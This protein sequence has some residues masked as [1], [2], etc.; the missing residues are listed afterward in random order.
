[1][2]LFSTQQIKLLDACTIEKEPVSSIDLMERAA[3]SIT[4]WLLQYFSAPNA[5]IVI[6]GTGNNGGDALAVARLLCLCGFDI[7]VYLV[8]QHNNLSPDCAENKQR[9]LQQGK[10]KFIEVTDWTQIRSAEMPSQ[11]FVLDGLFGSGLN[12]PLEGLYANVVKW[13]NKS[14]L[15]VISIDI[16]SGLF[17]E[18]N[19]ADNLQTIVRAQHTL[20][21]QFPK[22]AFLFPENEEFVGNWQL[23]NIGLHP[24][25]IN[26]TQSP[27]YFTEKEDIQ[28]FVKKRS[29]FSHKGAFGHALFVGGSY[30][31][32]GAAVLASQA[33]L[34]TG[35]GLLSVRSPECGTAILQTSV[36]E[37]MCLPDNEMRFIASLPDNLNIYSA[38]ACGC[39][40]GSEKISEKVVEYL[41][42][43]AT[44]PLALDADS[45]NIL[46][47]HADWLNLLPENTI[48]TPHPKEFERLAGAYKNRREQ[49]EQA[50]IFC[51]KYHIFV[52]L[53]GAYTAV[54]CP[55]GD[56][57]FNS[58]GN[59][60]M[61]TG[62]SG[63]VLCGMILSLLAQ[64][65]SP[66][67][68]ALL[69]VYL[70]GAAGDCA[71]QRQSEEALIASDVIS[72]IGKV[73]KEII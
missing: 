16:P 63:D 3:V 55:D 44:Q 47:K 17:G 2:K 37:A 68:S 65:Y 73:F 13:I 36:P 64:G 29:R 58:T 39:G 54:V 7:S 19:S 4:D 40:M 15:P 20:S 62:G 46:S 66:K 1:M 34:R 69:G 9:L 30:G 31:K 12:R 35:A 72:C 43:N 52:V 21:F 28:A 49:I 24:D 53:K 10:A 71:L 45:L 14:G 25:A 56:V 51:Q 26:E 50:R 27:Y 57:H 23:L 33:C 60:G 70:H 8:N 11:A 6:A 5:V 48:L 41:L 59:A 67:E 18:D 32:M 22:M 38:I 42:Q 61:A